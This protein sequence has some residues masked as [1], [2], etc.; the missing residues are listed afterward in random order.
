MTGPCTARIPVTNDFTPPVHT[1][2]AKT[3]ARYQ[4][5]GTWKSAAATATT[6]GPLLAIFAAMVLVPLPWTLL[7]IPVAAAFLV[8]TFIL[9]HDCCHGSL[10]RSH[11]ANE[12][13][14]FIAG[15]LTATPLK[16][17][18]RDHAI[19]H[20]TSGCL[21]A[22]GVGDIWTLTVREYLDA[23]RWVRLA[24]R[25]YRNPLFLLGI[26][27]VWLLVRQRWRT[28]KTA[29]PRERANVYLTNV[30]VLAMLAALAF[31]LGP[32][33]LLVTYLPAVELATAVGIG[34]F[35]VQHQFEGAYWARRGAWDYGSAAIAGSSYL[36][37]P[38][39]LD[40]ITGHIAFHHVHHLNPRIPHYNL[41][42][43]H[44]ESAMFGSIHVLTVRD[45]MRAFSLK[46]WDED[47]R[48]MIV[49]RELRDRQTV[50]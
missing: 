12:S 26:G 32:V 24:Y 37:R 27:P 38:R 28:K 14:G 35:Y 6:I 49:W 13:V 20:A 36:R 18:R 9:M 47:A 29:G 5:P 42:R 15:V 17:W 3:F 4:A 33:K 40:W 44:E 34:L 2:S 50:A 25:C 48:A 7:L 19:H 16:Q 31:L 41:R 30:G 11:R 46:L 22:R 43:S 8:R 23:G 39:L 21:D 45:S 10:F 1:S